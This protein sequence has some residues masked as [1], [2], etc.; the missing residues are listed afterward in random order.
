MIYR[1]GGLKDF[2]TD[3]AQCVA[4]LIDYLPLTDRLIQG[5][6]PANFQSVIYN[7]HPKYFQHFMQNNVPTFQ[8][9]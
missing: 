7:I 8:I 5:T 9:A 4:Y 1:D 2:I 3:G 6:T